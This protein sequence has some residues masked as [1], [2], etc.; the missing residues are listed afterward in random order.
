MGVY[1]RVSTTT[2]TLQTAVLQVNSREVWGRAR[3]QGRFPAV[4]AYLGP[5]PATDDG[6]EFET[7]VVP[8]SGGSAP[9]KTQVWYLADG[10][11]RAHPSDPS[12]A[13]LDVRIRHVR[14]TTPAALAS[15]VDVS[16]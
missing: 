11:A 13:V 6:I 7:E 9:R 10:H 4:K 15:A 3:Q 2:Q 5:L 16:L 8:S 1:H 12:F 14:Y